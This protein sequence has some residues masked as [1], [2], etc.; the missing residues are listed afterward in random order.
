MLSRK[1]TGGGTVGELQDVSNVASLESL[2]LLLE[3]SVD[4]H[5][6]LIDLPTFE[7]SVREVIEADLHGTHQSEPHVTREEEETHLESR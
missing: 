3:I 6:D 7:T 5:T 4:S 1:R 2:T